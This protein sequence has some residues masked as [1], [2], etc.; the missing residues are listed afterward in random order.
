MKLAVFD[1][2][3][4]LTDTN[5]VDDECFVKALADAHAIK[6]VST[7][8][9]AYPHTT[10]SGIL[11]HI[12]G[13]RFGRSPSASELRQFKRC[14]V[15][16]LEDR[17]SCGSDRFAE[18]P[19]ARAALDWLKQETAEWAVA[20]A[21]GCWRESA[22]MKSKAAK[23]EIDAIP[24]AFAE[25]G[26]SREEIIQEAISKAL[27]YYGQRDFEKVVSIGDGLWDV[28]AARRLAIPFLGVG[29]GASAATL[30]Q[31][32]AKHVVSDFS[33]VRQL[34]WSLNNAEIPGAENL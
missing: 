9:G 1:I 6:E 20:V 14:F 5:S 13:E 21:T 7:N 25:D 32:G 27:A 17:Y 11:S 18:I 31:A 15:G 8:W 3:G 16:L 23:I 12:F 29:S 2:D 10:D 34:I 30:R 24:A 33:D 28:R 26:I 22:L 19:G 4:T